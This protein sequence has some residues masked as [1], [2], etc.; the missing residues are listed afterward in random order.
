M[1]HVSIKMVDDDDDDEEQE[2]QNRRTPNQMYSSN[3]IKEINLILLVISCVGEL[4]M[5]VNVAENEKKKEKTQNQLH[6]LH[7]PHQVESRGNIGKKR[8]EKKIQKRK[9]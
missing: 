9:C 7:N 3:S 2:E 5:L 8:I 1:H 4:H 6:R